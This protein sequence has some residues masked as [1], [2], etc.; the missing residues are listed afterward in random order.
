[1]KEAAESYLGKE[2]KHAVITVPAYFNDAQLISIKDAGTIA[3]LG[4][5]RNVNDPT[6]AAIPY[7]LDKK[8]ERNI[9]VSDLGG[10][11][12]DHRVMQHF[13]KLFNKK[14]GKV[15]LLAADHEIPHC[16]IC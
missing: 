14:H 12:F 11:E 4:V 2:L 13:I 10:E 6:A 1:M 5:L 3:G 15:G 7:G 16:E 9:L 8:A